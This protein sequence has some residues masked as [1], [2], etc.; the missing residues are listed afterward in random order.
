MLF[1]FFHRNFNLEDLIF[2]AEACHTGFNVGLHTLL[3]AGVGVQ[4][5]PLAFE[6][7]QAVGEVFDG[8]GAS[9]QLFAALVL[10]GLFGSS[11][12]SRLGLSDFR[13]AFTLGLQLLNG[14]Y[15]LEISFWSFVEVVGKHFV[16]HAVSPS[17]R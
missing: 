9:I 1:D 12:S 6:G 2:H 7:A 14:S 13:N 15:G 17:S 3:I 16:S 5:V 4:H 10:R 11:F 8:L